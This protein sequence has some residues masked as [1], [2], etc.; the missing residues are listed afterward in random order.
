MTGHITIFEVV[1]VQ[2]FLLSWCGVVLL[3]QLRRQECPH[4]FPVIVSIFSIAVGVLTVL[5]V[6]DWM[7]YFTPAR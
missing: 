3:W 7:G 4:G 2:G 5:A 1:A 6:I